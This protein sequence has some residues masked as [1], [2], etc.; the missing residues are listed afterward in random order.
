[1]ATATAT[2]PVTFR[3]AKRF[4]FVV[5]SKKTGKVIESMIDSDNF[6][7]LLDIRDQISLEEDY[8]H[9]IDGE[10]FTARD[11]SHAMNNAYDDY[12][13]SLVFRGSEEC[14]H[15]LK[16]EQLHDREGND[17]GEAMCCT[18]CDH[19]EEV[20]PNDAFD[21]LEDFGHKE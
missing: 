21:R 5:T 20:A 6:G 1:M 4:D 14:S 18:K 17:N 15:D 7:R 9:D 16:L 8:D 2:T 3:S 11:L 12:T 19:T 10:D 13:H